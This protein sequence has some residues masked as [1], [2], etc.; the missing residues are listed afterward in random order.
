MIS[1]YSI[2]IV[3]KYSH[4]V[5]C[6]V[7]EQTWMCTMF[8]RVLF[9]ETVNCF[10]CMR[11]QVLLMNV[12]YCFIFLFNSTTLLCSHKQTL[13]YHFGRT[14]SHFYT[15]YDLLHPAESF[16]VL[17]FFWHEWIIQNKWNFNTMFPSWHL[18]EVESPCVGL[19]Y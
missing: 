17:L 5:I 8:T 19:F 15:L 6:T 4:V 11:C 1:H 14:I 9:F 18:F 16:V 3:P 2:L 13:H 10:V 7:R 12:S